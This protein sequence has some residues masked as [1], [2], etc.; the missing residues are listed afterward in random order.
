VAAEKR[1]LETMMGY[2]GG[3][4]RIPVIVDGETVMVGFNGRS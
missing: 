2:S 4:R 3:S 1:Q